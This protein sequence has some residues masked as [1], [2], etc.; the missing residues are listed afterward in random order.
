M[1]KNYQA[2]VNN[3][4]LGLVRGYLANA[5]KVA[6]A[7]LRSRILGHP[8]RRRSPPMPTAPINDHKYVT[9]RRRAVP[10]RTV[11]RHHRHR[12]AGSRR[13]GTP[14]ALSPANCNISGQW[15]PGISNWAFS[16]GGEYALPADFWGK[17]GEVYLGYDASYRSK[18]SSNASRSLY[19][20]VERLFA[21]QFPPRLPHRR[22]R[23]LLAVAAQCL[24]PGLFRA[25]VGHARQH[26]PDRRPAGR[27]QDLWRDPAVPVLDRNSRPSTILLGAGFSGVWNEARIF[28]RH[29]GG[30]SYRRRG[31]GGGCHPAECQ[32][33][34]DPRA[35]PDAG[36]QLRRA[37]RQVRRQGHAALQPWRF[38]RTGPR[39]DRRACRP[40]W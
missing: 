17:D 15:L 32:L 10:A 14:G 2:N 39:R 36:H 11:G 33:R 1:I 22:G 5:D 13:A 31:P 30:G 8:V 21:A 27:S 7:R 37:I 26:R 4:N 29:G 12:H 34:C 25:A 23:R 35:L 16:W 19:T 18:F 3:G 40:I 38:G 9:L 24:R 20:D 6:G 28:P